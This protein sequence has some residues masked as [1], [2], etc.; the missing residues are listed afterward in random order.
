MVLGRAAG[1]RRAAVCGREQ[2][3]H[4][5]QQCVGESSNGG[6]VSQKLALRWHSREGGDRV[7]E[8]A[9]IALLPQSAA[10]GTTSRGRD[11]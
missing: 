2:Q 7:R 10:D 1:A 8:G 11:L 4:A 9:P 5:E 3:E 6:N